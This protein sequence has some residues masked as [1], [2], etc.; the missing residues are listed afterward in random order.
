MERLSRQLEFIAEA[1]RLK[2]VL[3][4]TMLADP[5]RRENSAEH[6]WH[7]AVLAL[8]LAE[9]AL[10]GTDLAR[11]VAM[12]TLHDLVEVDAGD[13]SAYAPQPDQVRQQAAE[14]AA[15]D[16]LFALLP[17]DQA[18]TM[19]LLW[20]E[21]EERASLEARFARALDRLQP[22]LENVKMGGGTWRERG[23]TADDVLTKVALIED[24]SPQLGRFARDLIERAVRDGILAPAPA[25]E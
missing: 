19:R 21:F 8:T 4:Q 16:R 14:R 11:V 22:V 15:A 1:G 13:L 7:L 17:A 10:P 24:G 20:D 6:S 9:Y 5:A 2:G 23:V 3:R 18:G 12:L 25:G